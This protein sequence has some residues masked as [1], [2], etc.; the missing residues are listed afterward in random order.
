M[1]DI[2]DIDG[3]KIFGIRSFTVRLGQE[4]VTFYYTHV[5]QIKFYQLLFSGH[6]IFYA[7]LWA[8]ILDMYMATSNGLWCC[9]F[10]GSIIILHVEQMHHGRAYSC[11]ILNITLAILPNLTTF[12][13]KRSVYFVI[14][15]NHPAF[16]QT[17][18]AQFLLIV[19]IKCICPYIVTCY[20]I[21]YEA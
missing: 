13:F 14:N 19:K 7:Y 9:H 18:M 8:G 15:L 6:Y 4:R 12:G 21:F 11:L 5:P 2:P 20:F 1:Q 3:D 16:T 10:S 17:K